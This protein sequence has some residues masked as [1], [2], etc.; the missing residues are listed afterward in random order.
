[1]DPNAALEEMLRLSETLTS[2]EYE[3]DSGDL[4][5]DSA[6]LAELVLAL[7]GWITKGGFLPV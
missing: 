5:R 7:N 3:G 2:D 1:M 6:R 4:L